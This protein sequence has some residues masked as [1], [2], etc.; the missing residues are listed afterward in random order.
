MAASEASEGH[1]Q[2]H[3]YHL[4]HL[5]HYNLRKTGQRLR[6]LLHPDG[7][8]VHIA[9]NP[10]EA[11]ELKRTLSQD[12]DEIEIFIHGS[13]EH[14]EALRAIHAHHDQRRSELRQQHGHLFEQ[15]EAACLELEAL[16]EV[17]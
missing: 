6:H 13:D 15:A 1:P 11:E 14:L 7:R 12:D 9:Q 4:P 2:H 5:P 16:S 17:G 10:A 3:H 8:K